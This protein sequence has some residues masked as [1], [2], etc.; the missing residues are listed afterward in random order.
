MRIPPEILHKPAK[1]TDEEME[2]MKRHTVYGYEMVRDQTPAVTADVVLNHHQR[3]N[4][5]GY[6]DWTDERT[7]ERHPPLAGKE[8]AILSRI[9]TIADVYDAATTNRVYSRAKLPVQVLHEMR[10]WCRGFFD[11]VVEH[12]FFEAI[13]PFPIGQIVTLNDGSEAAVVDFNPHDPTRPKVQLLREPSGVR[14]MNTHGAE[15][16]LSVVD[17]LDVTSVDGVD[18][19]PFQRTLRAEQAPVAVASS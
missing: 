16:D 4:G 9:A 6:P 1:L 13:P 5:A 12:A 18:V 19:R 15:I 14:V 7:G 11:P 8:I 2:I 3:F 17:Q 10:T